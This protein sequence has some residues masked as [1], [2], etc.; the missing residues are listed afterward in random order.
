MGL[1][2][3]L[4]GIIADFLDA[5]RRASAEFVGAGGEGLDGDGSV[6]L[7][8]LERLHLGGVGLLELAEA[9]FAGLGGGLGLGHDG[10]GLGDLGLGTGERGAAGFDGLQ[11]LR[12]G[13][14]GGF[15]FGGGLGEGEFGFGELGLGGVILALG[16]LGFGDALGDLGEAGLCGGFAGGEGGLDLRGGFLGRGDVRLEFFL[17]RGF[18]AE[19]LL[20]KLLELRIVGDG[21]AGFTV[22][23][24]LG[25]V[26]LH[27]GGEAELD[28]FAGRDEAR[29]E[30]GRLG[31]EAALADLQFIIFGAVELD[32]GRRAA[33][34]FAVEAD[35]RGG[36]IRGDHDRVE[37]GRVDRGLAAGEGD[38]KGEEGNVDTHMTG[39][40]V[41]ELRAKRS[42]FQPLIALA[43]GRIDTEAL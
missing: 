17:G 11:I 7:R 8:V 23:G 4:G 3:G 12:G 9:I 43:E 42:W 31:Q 37:V 24:L 1:G 15:G 16:G 39:L 28:A 10:L 2:K 30:F 13:F 32:G 36:R 29:L 27:G 38:A 18:F 14:A 20:G 34:G 5:G 33:D 26:D 35:R 21:H 19:R 41:S 6:G 40:G 25:E 22:G